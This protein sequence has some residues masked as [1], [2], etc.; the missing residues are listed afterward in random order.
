[1]NDFFSA[2][3]IGWLYVQDIGQETTYALRN[4]SDEFKLELM[5]HINH[6][7]R[8]EYCTSK[9]NLYLGFPTSRAYLEEYFPDNAKHEV[10][11]QQ[12]KMSSLK[13]R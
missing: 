12:L 2:N 11:F 6:Y 5:G 4:I 7:P 3:Y 8:S 13:K 9:A 10:N 1:M